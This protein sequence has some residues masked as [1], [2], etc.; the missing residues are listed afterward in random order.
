MC[1]HHAIVGWSPE[2]DAYGILRWACTVWTGPG[3]SER[4]R[5]A[6]NALIMQQTVNT[7]R[8]LLFMRAMMSVLRISADVFFE[9]KK[10]PCRTMYFPR[11]MSSSGLDLW[12]C[13][14]LFCMGSMRANRFYHLSDDD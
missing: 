2:F 3:Y 10:C 14:G 5:A 4:L 8:V 12:H 9:L 1:F 11:Q 13:P 7:Q 6:L